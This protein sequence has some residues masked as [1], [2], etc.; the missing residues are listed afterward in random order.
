VFEHK[1]ER[2]RVQYTK[3]EIILYIRDNGKRDVDIL[4]QQIVNIWARS[5][6]SQSYCDSCDRK[7]SRINLKG[8]HRQSGNVQ[9]MRLTILLLIWQPNKANLLIQKNRKAFIY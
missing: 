7:M 3:Q 1:G 4:K 9:T 5:E 8:E 6:I 2:L